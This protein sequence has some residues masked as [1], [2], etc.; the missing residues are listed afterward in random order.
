MEYSQQLRTTGSVG[1]DMRNIIL[2]EMKGRK[3]Q[4]PSQFYGSRSPE[5]NTS[6]NNSEISRYEDMKYKSNY[7]QQLYIKNQSKYSKRTNNLMDSAIKD[8]KVYGSPLADTFL[9]F[10][11][12]MIARDK[13]YY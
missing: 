10:K 7:Y 4:Q 1:N 12:S 5:L 2:K 9:D 8:S 3:H 13:S 6:N 11:D